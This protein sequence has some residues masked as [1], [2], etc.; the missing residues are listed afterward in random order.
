MI[1]PHID[2]AT[3]VKISILGKNYHTE[4]F[5]FIDPANVPVEFGG[6]DETPFGESS[7]EVALREYVADLETNGKEPFTPS[8]GGATQFPE[9]EA[10]EEASEG[11]V[12]GVA[13]D[14]AKLA[15]EEGGAAEPAPKAA[16][17]P[18]QFFAGY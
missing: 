3:K 12:D 14:L 15:T 1:S 8:G 4:L 2:P 17:P 16:A 13:D 9:E 7:Q 6:T 18:Q 5:E 10:A 11:D